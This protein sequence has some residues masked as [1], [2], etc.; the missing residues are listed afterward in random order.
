MPP[1]ENITV[2][3]STNI[4]FPVLE[5]H[6]N[7]RIWGDDAMEFKPE[8]FMEENIKK[9]HPY[10]FIPFSNGPRMCPGYKYAMMALKIFVSRFLMRYKVSTSM[11]Y[12]ELKF[13]VGLTLKFQQP[14]L[15]NIEK[16]QK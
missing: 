15:L 6:R 7:K 3:A 16:R 4:I 13:I 1:P 2:P 11:K 8:R 12:E 14:P 9:I 5:I 10:A